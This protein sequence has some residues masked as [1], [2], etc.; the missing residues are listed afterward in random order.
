MSIGFI[1][2]GWNATTNLKTPPLEETARIKIAFKTLSRTF[3][4]N[5][6]YT[7]I[8]RF[9]GNNNFY[10]EMLGKKKNRNRVVTMYSPIVSF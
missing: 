9:S 3:L 6:C 1:F 10:S 4:A 5:F 8:R 2:A 7:V